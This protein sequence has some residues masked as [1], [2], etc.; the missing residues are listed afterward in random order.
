MK[1]KDVSCRCFVIGLLAVVMSGLAQF[2][3]A[4]GVS[5]PP[6]PGSPAVCLNEI[7]AQ[8]YFSG[9]A[10]AAMRGRC[11]DAASAA[12]LAEV[13]KVLKT[14]KDPTQRRR[15]AFLAG[16]EAVDLGERPA[17]KRHLSSLAGGYPLLEDYVR[18]HL[19]EIAYADERWPEAAEHFA[20]LSP[21]S[22]LFVQAQ[23]RAASCLARQKRPEAAETLERLIAAHPDHF[24]ITQA[25]AELADRLSAVDPRR[26]RTLWLEVMSEEPKT[27]FGLLAESRLAAWPKK[28]ITQN[29]REAIRLAWANRHMEQRRFAEA[30]KLVDEGLKKCPPKASRAACGAWLELQGRLLARASKGEKAIAAFSSVAETKA[31]GDVQ[32]RALFDRL[33]AEMR[34]DRDDAAIAAGEALVA[35]YPN[36]P[37][38]CEAAFLV[39]SLHRVEDRFDEAAVAF[40]RVVDKYPDCERAAEALWRAGWLQYRQGRYDEAER[41]WAALDAYVPER[42]DRERVLYWRARGLQKQGDAAA[43]RLYY[44]QVLDLHPL[45]FYGSLAYD[46]LVELGVSPSVSEARTADLIGLDPADVLALDVSAEAATP[47]FQRALELWRLDRRRDARREF[48]ALTAAEPRNET[49][50]LVAAYLHH[51]AGEPSVAI[52]YFRVAID[53][54]MDR[55]P[56]P[57]TVG[58]WRLAYP[59]PYRDLILKEAKAAGVEPWLVF[60]LIREESSFQADIRSP[61]GAM[62]LMQIMSY[63]GRPVAK[64]LGVKKFKVSDLYQPETSVRFGSY[65]LA[66]RLEG[67]GGNVARAVASYNAGPS[68]VSRWLATFG[69]LPVDEFMEEIPYRETRGYTRRVLKSWGIYRY[70]YGSESPGLPLGD[71]PPS[72]VAN[73]AD[74]SVATP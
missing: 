68:A 28:P 58:L 1:E 51:L 59:T 16:M 40:H 34:A 73:R 46:R 12:C 15:L 64:K 54:F 7:D 33:Q 41:V 37:L 4:D 60:A 45:G 27:G 44:E 24:R 17:A 43:S 22:R 66:R 25:K 2:A 31:A 10:Y 49:Y 8:P 32:G 65:Y 5:S 55:Y 26:A 11:A 67:F 57:D 38:A 39:A 50:A 36:H 13:E 47:G 3:A 63:T 30:Q 62:G 72:P 48:D 29:E 9:P 53:D 74:Q 61:V 35:R 18:Y 20:A 56:T 6:S 21:D 19:G 69:D 70:L 23:F 71:K 14:E 52:H 42:L